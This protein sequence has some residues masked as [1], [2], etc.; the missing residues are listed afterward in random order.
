M[1]SERELLGAI[2]HAE[3]TELLQELVRRPSP[4]PPGCEE[5]VARFIA[6][7]CRDL[8]LRIEIDEV[9]AGRP[10]VCASLGPTDAPGLLFL[11]HTDTVPAGDGWAHP[12]FGGVLADGRVIGRGA[13]DMKAGIAAAAVAMAALKRCGIELTRSVTLAAVID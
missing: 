1:V 6:D 2:G 9:E 13:A 4:N 3:L 10:N 12:P 7:A 5:P 11:A 8:G